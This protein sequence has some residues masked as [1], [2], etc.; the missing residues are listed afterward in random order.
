MSSA[1]EIRVLGDFAVRCD[2]AL[3]PLPQS[4]KT[5]ALLA[6]LA[7][8]ERPQRRERLCEMFWDV[9]DDPRGALRWSLSKLRPILNADG[10]TRLTAD[11]NSVQLEPGSVALDYE[12]IRGMSPDAVGSLPTE[13]LEKIA[14]AFA[15]PFLS[16]LYLPRCP[17]FEAWRTY[18]ANETEI[19]RLKV[20][21]AL[22]D[23]LENKPERALAHLHTLQSLLLDDDLSAEIARINDRARLT[24]A[25]RPIAD[26]PIGGSAERPS[27]AP[28]LPEPARGLVRPGSA[29]VSSGTQ[30]I[31]YAH[32]RDGA[33]IAF[34]VSGTGPAI[35]RASHWMSHLDFDWES[36][37]W[38][39]WIDALSRGFTLLRY[40]GR[41]NGLSDTAC[42]DISFEAFISDLERVV[43]AA[44][45]D[46]FVLLGISQ[47][48]ALSVEYANRHPEK[49][50]GLVICGGYVRGWR[51]RG[52]ASEIAR[53]EAIS[54][55]MRQGWGQDDPLFRQMF[56][57]LFIPGANRLQMDWFNELQRRTLTPD[58]ALRLNFAFADVD[59]SRALERLQLPTL[60]L[61]SSGDRVVPFSEGQEIARAITGARFIELDSANHILLAE[62]PAFRRFVLEVSRFANDALQARTAVTVDPRTRRQATI[63]GASFRYPDQAMESLP[64]DILL[65]RVDPF[66][67]QT[68]ALV[69]DNGG[70]VLTVS[71]NELVA[72]FG[73]PE[74]LEGHAALACRTALA[75]RELALGHA[76]LITA[77]RVA[78]DT[79]IVIVGRAR[80]HATE[81]RGG[82]VSVAHALS[83]VLPRDLVVATARTRASAG[84]FVSMQ[85]LKAPVVSEHTKDQQFFK[86][87]EIRRGRSRWQLRADTQ[88]SPFIGREMQLQMLNKAW[89]DACG[90]EGQTVFVVGDPGLGKSR[91]THEFVGAIPHDEAENLE[92]GAL[93]MD[94]RSGFVVIRKV[95]QAL[96]GVGDT[97]AVAAAVEKV[98]AA[99]RA[100][101]F[102]ERLLA[103]IMAIMELPVADPSWAAISSQERSRRMQEAAVGLLLFL[104]RIRPV[105]LLVEDLQWIDAESEAVLARLTQA[106]PTVRFLLILTCRPEYD[107][108]GFAAAGPA[109]IRLPTFNAAEAAALL[110]HL[111]GSDPQLEQ[112]RDAVL[113]A[114]KG[115]ALFLE[116]TVRAL[117]ETGKL[118]GQPGRYRPS[119]MVGEIAVSASI[120][121]IVD[122]RFERLDKD[123]KRVAEVASIF[124]GEIPVLLLR[125]MAALSNLRFDAALQSLRKADLLVDVDV[126]PEASVAF[127]HAL[128]RSAVSGH[129]VS[130]ALV[131]LHSTALAELKTYYA[132]RLEE[133]SERLARHAEQAHLWDEAAGYLLVS[134]R[135]AIKRSAHASAL[136]QLD[137]GI[138]L[139]RSNEVADADDR[140]I[141][142]QIARGVALMAARGWGSTEVLA[143]FE[144]AEKLCGKIGD[145]ARLFTALRGR[146]QYYMISGKPAA[147]QELAC[148]WAGMVKDDSDPG[149]AIE[150]E[151]MFWTN[152]FFLGETSAAHDHA[153]RAIG[154]YDPDRDH[155]LTYK[156]SGHD[157]GVCCR[158]F[159]GLSAWLAGEPD[160]ARL[161][162]ED[163]IVLAKRLD[164]PL[165]L[166]LAY[167]GMS[168][169]HMFAGEPEATVRAAET[170][171]KI[172]EKFQ[173]PLL[174]GQAAFQVGWGQF[175]LGQRDAGLHR[176][177]EAISAI[178]R[179]GAEMGLPYLM[180]LYAE[181][182]G[183]SGRLDGARKS[184]EAAL[185]L[186]RHNGTYFQLAEVLRIEARIRERGGGGPDE[187]DQLLQ[188][189]ANVATLQRSAIGGLRV[190]VELAHRLRMRGEPDK[191]REL[192]A[193]HGELVDKLGDSEDARAAREFA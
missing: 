29:R 100:Q 113:D 33:R 94:L 82:P 155:Y 79:G 69:R 128:I 162:C 143:A 25:A 83:Q 160:M 70:T 163:A 130:S 151:H 58:N 110:D 145:Q 118:E 98:L 44:G 156:Y 123:A 161:R 16:D 34:T 50:A 140:E 21:R 75:L 173:L 101:D 172:A 112:L 166:S 153:E 157:P 189:A 40:D 9:P 167:W 89:H 22:V 181:A 54:E 17:A 138:W 104:G 120:Q 129:I 55:L 35:V 12:Q 7:V 51:A 124:G 127:K 4:R 121:T 27:A 67:T 115:N 136:E 38:G 45:L 20:L 65:E 13:R 84:G 159:A 139:L 178:R 49:V 68:T 6:Y 169:F 18:C 105:V 193:T 10:Q 116:E 72:S 73:A 39:H 74:P 66:L 36:P 119:G 134:A 90:S 78:L 88:L 48:S 32:G 107:R 61:H 177:A 23:H 96:F 76:E 91:V 109:E 60:V 183:D 81:V 24:V 57:N 150:T 14:A 56:T 62:E 93:E 80:E 185:E 95:L 190:A 86:V 117:A 30:Q 15:G 2:G 132:D 192:I 176:M 97:E 188:K 187:I 144:R 46:R 42:Q 154:L 171:L 11:R 53:R 85:A 141:E 175:R 47:G 99:R 179:T 102:D 71:E 148:R 92:V 103:P 186:G 3:V 8:V 152:N 170:E 59:I 158:C 77:F 87:T 5:R 126:F 31:R 146:A 1:F 125:R 19:L 64:P 135:K 122:A 108:S 165:S 149:L 184:V 180:G 111:V 52:I 131:E 142:F 133:H 106:V 28:L 37:V 26:S 168:N 191:A 43:E 174:A 63:L 147:A 182:L 114:C 41:L 164:H 137:L